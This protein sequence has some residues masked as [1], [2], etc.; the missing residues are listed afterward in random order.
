[1]Q[2]HDDSDYRPAGPDAV[3][4]WLVFVAAL[5]ATLVGGY[6]IGLH[7]RQTVGACSIL[8]LVFALGSVV[9]D[10]YVRR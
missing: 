1:M 2:D 8:M 7:D 4:G 9:Y 3:V 10:H 5:I 6:R